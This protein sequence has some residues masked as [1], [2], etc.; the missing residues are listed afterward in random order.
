MAVIKIKLTVYLHP[1]LLPEVNVLT[2]VNQMPAVVLATTAINPP[3][4]VL[5][6]NPKSVNLTKVSVNPVH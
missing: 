6:V 2:P 5:C 3:M 4:V 1:P